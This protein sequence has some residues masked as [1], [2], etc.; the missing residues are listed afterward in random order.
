MLKRL[1]LVQKNYDI[2][3]AKKEKRIRQISIWCSHRE[4]QS[5]VV[6]RGMELTDFQCLLL[7]ENCI[8]LD[9]AYKFHALKLQDADHEQDTDQTNPTCA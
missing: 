9:S 6:R 4:L 5:A 3:K 2:F 8:S 7:E 1:I